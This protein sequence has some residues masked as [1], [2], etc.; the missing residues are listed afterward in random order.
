[1]SNELSKE[2]ELGVAIS[3]LEDSLLELGLMSDEDWWS[4]ILFD[5]LY[6]YWENR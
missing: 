4:C 1:M 6:E 2:E 5:D 3:N